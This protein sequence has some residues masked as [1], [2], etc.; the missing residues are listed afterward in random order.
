MR[1]I[2]LSA[3]YSDTRNHMAAH[4]HDCHQLLYITNG[5]IRIQVSGREYPAGPGTIV[6]ISRFEEHSIQVQSS[7]YHRYSLRI[8]PDP[9]LSDPL[10]SLLVNRPEHFQH[11]VRLGD[12][13]GAEELFA[14]IL[15][16]H[17]SGSIMRGKMLELLLL[18]L[19]VTVYRSL[20]EIIPYEQVD[21]HLIRSIQ[22]QFES[23][24][25]AK[26]TLQSLSR[27]HHVSPSHLS[28]QFKQATGTSV[29]GYLNSCRFAAAK[30]YLAETDLEIGRVVELCG[31]SDNSNFS[32]SFKNITGLTPTEFRIQ[33]RHK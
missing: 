20:P 10:F 22:Q 5:Q 28:H 33:F 2:I 13:S 24:F 21:L 17:Q 7:T 11:A 1:S 18:Q 32:R 3:D 29:M 12:D 31:F 8:A 27:Q 15:R 6:L 26:Y 9:G 23:N 30:R 4:Y 19:L 16:E 25:I 14:R